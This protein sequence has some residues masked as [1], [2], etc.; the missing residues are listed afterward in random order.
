MKKNNA[1]LFLGAILS[2]CLTACD[3]NG[4]KDNGTDSY[5]SGKITFTADESFAPI[6]DQELYV[7][8]SLY[9]DAKPNILY[10]SENDALRLFLNDSVRVAILARSLTADE[11]KR[12][13]AK[14]LYPEVNCF[15]LME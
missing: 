4:K 12:L 14:S 2:L 11:L 15:A 7:F 13:R 6:L 9:K 10:K 8:T 5:T 3:Q 1:F